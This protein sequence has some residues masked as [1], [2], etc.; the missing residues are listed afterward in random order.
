MCSLQ[1]V[2]VSTN[3][4]LESNTI[5]TPSALPGKEKL[6]K[7]DL[8]INKDIL[9]VIFS[10]GDKASLTEASYTSSKWNQT[11]STALKEGLDLQLLKTDFYR[12][13]ELFITNGYLKKKDRIG[14]GSL[15]GTIPNEV[16]NLTFD[17][18]YLTEREYVILRDPTKLTDEILDQ[19][20]EELAKRI[21][22]T[23]RIQGKFPWN[24]NI[25]LSE[26][27]F[28]FLHTHNIRCANKI[29]Y[30][31]QMFLTNTTMYSSAAPD[32]EEYERDVGETRNTICNFCANWLVKKEQ[33]LPE[34]LQEN[35]N[36]LR[37][38]TR[39]AND[40]KESTWRDQYLSHIATNYIELGKFS[41]AITMLKTIS[42]PYVRSTIG[43]IA[44]LLVKNNFIEAGL[45]NLRKL[46]PGYLS[47][48]CRFISDELIKQGQ[49]IKAS[50]VI[51]LMPEKSFDYQKAKEK[52]L[53][54]LFSSENFTA[55]EAVLKQSGDLDPTHKHIINSVD[56]SRVISEMIDFSL[57]KVNLI[58]FL[59][60][61]TS[62]PL[63]NTLFPAIAES[64]MLKGRELE[65][66]NIA[67]M[68]ED[69]IKKEVWISRTS[70]FLTASKI[71]GKDNPVEF[72]KQIK[73][74]LFKNTIFP[75]LVQILVLAKK[76]PAEAIQIAEMI[77]DP[78]KKK[79]SLEIIRIFNPETQIPTESVATTPPVTSSIK[80]ESPP[81][82]SPNQ[83]IIEPIPPRPNS[84]PTN[85]TRS[86]S[87]THP[88]THSTTRP[89]APTTV[90]RM[91]YAKAAVSHL[92]HRS[93]VFR[94]L[95][96]GSL[97]L[98]PLLTFLFKLVFNKP[99]A[100]SSL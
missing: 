4:T 92:W 55:L 26:D 89:I 54:K 25:N 63:R 44:L 90:S 65:A 32:T 23:A 67:N 45:E 97:G 86:E 41:K 30:L 76:R 94:V 20:L 84:L 19:G 58:E 51:N 87:S 43:D 9:G 15:E 28:R 81:P 66:E 49:Y 79:N 17:N 93:F 16:L 57:T 73:S 46:D 33:L 74:S 70:L 12:A 64:F 37:V 59:S 60:K 83:P 21:S 100:A 50:E 35:L 42:T 31:I 39:I 3:R 85:A 1:V 72:S 36:I 91:D 8:L 38:A 18:G 10:F 6:T 14:L 48:Y 11:I 88:I 71:A 62:I 24:T 98:I 27:V 29:A 99:K 95:S 13:Q 5:R 61:I 40:L 22:W 68:I 78:K 34:K 2:S 96:V 52:L 77:E 69:P 80:P 47:S 7:R 82:K 56:N 75:D 53:I